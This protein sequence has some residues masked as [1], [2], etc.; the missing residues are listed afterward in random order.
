[1]ENVQDKSTRNNLERTPTDYAFTRNHLKVVGFI[2][3][4]NFEPK[5]KRRKQ[6]EEGL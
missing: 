1:M 4:Y 2:L 5:L 3:N 6:E